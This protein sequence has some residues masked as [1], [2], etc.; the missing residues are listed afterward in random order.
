M[1]EIPQGITKTASSRLP[2]RLLASLQSPI[3]I[4]L[5]LLAIAGFVVVTVN[6][7]PYTID[8]AFITFRYAENL[9]NGWG[10]SFNQSPP[11]VEGYTSLLWTL[12]MAIPHAIGLDAVLVSKLLGVSLTLATVIVIWMAIYFA[13]QKVPK[14]GG[15]LVAVFGPIL[16][17]SFPYCAV[18][19][20]SGMETALAAFLYCTSVGQFLQLHQRTHARWLLPL[21]CFLLGVTRPEAN[22]FCTL[23]LAVALL[24]VPKGQ[25]VKFALCC[26]T[27][28]VLPGAGYF[29]WRYSY[30]GM[31][32]P[33]PFYIKS[34]QVGLAG[35]P[36]SYDFL[37]DIAL[38]FTLPLLAFI[39]YAPTRQKAVLL[40]LAA[41]FAY[42]L[43][44][45]HIT[46]YGDRY[47]Y[48][49]L[50]VLSVLGGLGIARMIAALSPQASVWTRT[51]LLS[52]A[53]IALVVGF[54]QGQYS[55]GGFLTYAQGLNRAHRVLGQ[56]LSEM[57]WK[58]HPVLV[59]ADAGTVP[60]YSR[61]ETIDSF[62]L[63]DAFIATHS[64]SDRSDYVFAHNPTLVVLIS[65]SGDTFDSPLPYENALFKACLKNGYSR[66]TVFRFCEAYYLWTMW[67]PDSPDAPMLDNL[68]LQASKQSQTILK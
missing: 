31:L 44:V 48:P 10:L 66:Q 5:I 36:P 53:A 49:L 21:M 40:P 52:I 22:L 4:G 11:H 51:A 27:C 39:F 34:G 24:S 42:F 47:F 18:H 7:W 1:T 62:G 43:T 16:F 35:L 32:F 3:A 38:A 9:T 41:M 58:S 8:D 25:R 6:T 56:T 12:V 64:R 37:K 61:L 67:H 55:A 57:R 60:Y 63:N 33:L 17:L 13:A 15:I 54:Q 19:S 28:Y 29:A 46:G 65:W 45:D 20:V 23:L 30:Y 50:P 2:N 26:F 59:I 14:A 68:L